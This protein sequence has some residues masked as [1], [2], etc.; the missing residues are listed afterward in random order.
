MGREYLGTVVTRRDIQRAVRD[1]GLSGLPVC[2]HV[3]FRSFGRVEGGAGAIVSAFLAQGCTVLAP[4]F[5]D[6][7]AVPPPVHIR[8]ERNGWNYDDYPGPTEGVGR[9][10]S[11]ETDEITVE[12]MG[13]V[14]AYLAAQPERVRGRHP[15]CSFTAIGPMAGELVSCQTPT[16]VFAPLRALAGANGWVLLMGVR[17]EKMTLL[18]A[19]E[20]SAGRRLFIR[21][22]NGPDGAAMG[23]TTGGCSDG[24]GRFETVLSPLAGKRQVGESPWTVYPAHETLAAAAEA[25]RGNPEITRCGNPRC[26]RCRDA[27]SG[28]PI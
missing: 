24:F 19:A 7:F 6:G 13:A 3:S 28:G 15:L 14:A 16:D 21:W 9:V 10:F 11:L 4:T 17:L 26:Q 1:L 18:H 5:S 25:I 23:V 22:A 8:P 12:E 20:E 27:I 2:L